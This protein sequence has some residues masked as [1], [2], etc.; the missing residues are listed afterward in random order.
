[1][2]G[3]FLSPVLILGY[4]G[5][6][7]EVAVGEVFYK[8]AMRVVLPIIVGQLMR[9]FVPATVEFYKKHKQPFKKAQE[10]ALVFIVYTTFCSTF[11]TDNSEFVT[12]VD[13]VVMVAVEFVCLSGLMLLAWFSMPLFLGKDLEP[14]LRVMGLFGCTHKTVAM[15]VPMINAI[16]E[17]DPW[18]GL[19]ILPLL[20]WHTMQLVL[21]SILVPKLAKWVESEEERRGLNQIDDD[22]AAPNDDEDVEAA[23]KRPQS[24]NEDIAADN[25]TTLACGSM[26]DMD[27]TSQ[28]GNTTRISQ[29][30]SAEC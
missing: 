1:M 20:I 10:L 22:D 30:R 27:N 21:G 5:V 19:I 12:G 24:T 11:S 16:Y 13:I 29:L 28:T 7:S 25:V 23:E 17:S 8:L 15:G 6:T 4:L 9:N 18:I 14:K 2:I 26:D 3:V